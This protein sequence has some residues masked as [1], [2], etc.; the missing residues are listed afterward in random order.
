MMEKITIL[1]HCRCVQVRKIT[2][3]RNFNRECPYL[4][5]TFF[6]RIIFIVFLFLFSFNGFSQ[7]FKEIGQSF[8]KTAKPLLTFGT[9]NAFVTTRAIK[10]RHIIAGL[11]YEDKTK[12]GLSF[13][14]QAKGFDLPLSQH[15]S[16]S[17]DSTKELRSLYLSAWM[18]YVF[19][20]NNGFTATIPVQI[21]V[22]SVYYRYKSLEEKWQRYGHSLA[23]FYE[24]TMTAAYRFWK[25]FE[26]G[27]GVGYRLAFKSAKKIE[28]RL[29][30]PVYVY[31]LKIYFADI[32]K[33][34]FK[35]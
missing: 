33:E 3:K 1:K 21:G 11:N 26:I 12:I 18:E 19:Y 2:R 17:L 14:W 20:Q 30:S 8:E 27:I 13:N 25:Y 10:M 29:S 28:Q 4:L 6:M 31:G 24:P 35:K 9:R 32:Y 16:E 23:V 34:Q 22:G 5:R 15:L 7:L